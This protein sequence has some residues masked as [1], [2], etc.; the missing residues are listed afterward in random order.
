[1]DSKVASKLGAVV[2]TVLAS[3]LATVMVVVHTEFA[4]FTVKTGK[5]SAVSSVVANTHEKK[6]H[7]KQHV[8]RAAHKAKAQQKNQLQQTLLTQPTSSNLSSN[9]YADLTRAFVAANIPWNAIENPV[10]RQFL[11]KYC[12]QNIPS[13]STL[14]KNY[15][16]RIYNETLASIREDISDSYTWVSVDE[17]SDPMN[18]YIANM[19]V[20]KL[21]PDGPSIPHLVCVKELSKVNSQAIAYFVNKGLQSLY[22]GNIDDSK[23]LLFCTDAA[24]YMVAAAP[25]LKTFYPNLTHVTCLAHGLHRVS[26]TIRNGFPLANSFFSNTKKC[27]CK[28]PSRISIF[29]ENF[30]DIPLPPQPVVTRWGT[31][32]QSVVYYSKYF[33]EVVTVIDKLPETDSAACVKAVKDCLNDSR[34]KKDIAYITSNF[35]FIPAS[36]E[37]LEREKQSLCSQIAIVKG[38]QVNI[39]SAL[40][41]TGKKTAPMDETPPCEP[42]VPEATKTPQRSASPIPNNM[43][44]SVQLKKEEED[45]KSRK[46]RRSSSVEAGPGMGQ[47]SSPTLPPPKV[48]NI[49]AQQPTARTVTFPMGVTPVKITLTTTPGRPTVTTTTSA[50]TTQKVIIVS[51]STASGS[52]S[53]LQRSLSVP[54]VKTVSATCSSNTLSQQSRG[55]SLIINNQSSVTMGAPTHPGPSG[56]GNIVTISTNPGSGGNLTATTVSI[57]G[58]PTTAYITSQSGVPKIRPKSVQLPAKPRPRSGSIVIPMTPNQLAG[59]PAGSSQ[60][61]A[62]LPNVQGVQLKTALHSSKPSLHIKQDSTGMK[63]MP[64][65]NVGSTTKILPKPSFNSG[66]Q[67]P[68]YVMSATTASVSMVTRT[69]P[70]S[71][72]PRVMT[73]NS[74]SSGS[75]PSTSH[76][77][78][79]GST[80]FITKNPTKPI[81]A[82][83]I[84]AQN[85]GIARPTGGKPN[86]IVVQKGSA[87]GFSRGVTLSHGGKEVM[88]KVIMSKSLTSSN[89]PSSPLTTVTVQKPATV[90]QPS[91]SGSSNNSQQTLNLPVSSTQGNVIV[92]DLSQEQLSKNSVLAEILQASGILSDSGNS[93]SENASITAGE[94]SRKA[95][96]SEWIQM[97]SEEQRVSTELEMA[98]SPEEDSSPQTQ[99][100]AIETLDMT[101]GRVVTLEEAVELLGQSDTAETRALLS[102]AGIQVTDSVPSSH[103]VT[104]PGTSGGQN[105]NLH[106]VVHQDVGDSGGHEMMEVIGELDPQTGIYSIHHPAASGETSD[107]IREASSSTVRIVSTSS[108]SGTMDIFSTALASADINLDSFQYMEDGMGM[109]FST[110]V[111]SRKMTERIEQRYCIKFCQKLGENMNR[112][113]AKFVPKLLS[114]EQKDLRR[115]VAQDLLDTANTDPGFLNTVITGD[116]SWVY[117][118]DPETK[119]Q[120]S[121]WK[122]PES[123]RPKKA[124][125]VRSKIKVML[126]VFF[127]VRGIVHHEY[128][129]E[130]QTV[131]KEYYH[132]V[133]WR[134]RDA[135]RRKRPDMWTANNWHLHHD[136]APAHS[137][138]LIHTFLAKH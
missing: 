71:S 126:T 1:M 23:V 64:M 130:G 79:T 32:I 43:M 125:Q 27:F 15:L 90:V 138:Q 136:N 62:N 128:A 2:A 9:F 124:R 25:L 82:V 42:S 61:L 112:V 76:I 121:Q 88:G 60:T 114:P 84:S 49:P 6:C 68:V 35:S 101:G 120:S 44:S 74:T 36:I 70:A 97:E 52:P 39:H 50:S 11:Q 116:E 110:F 73:V 8:Q 94:A 135:V 19:V 103:Q 134:L 21:S 93:S 81:Q 63:I 95:S 132:D 96:S 51:S 75:T 45:E 98:E 56:V 102:Q 109:F 107:T 100:P 46:R 115:D 118:Y 67:A 86:V 26:E 55:A 40:G 10:L 105:N 41:E 91:G 123:P 54:I 78:P 16:D 4:L 131:T 17:T 80:T 83:H 119:R 85:P 122:H 58:I 14:R 59:G 89:L 72:A 3:M 28:A 29:R 57:G 7:L 20:R 37:Q 13:E 106:Q 108:T 92:L 12:K 66:T 22:S 87:T 117:G 5:S 31:W 77:R 24:S 137:S 65:S 113:A 99:I 38:A 47:P 18:R 33:K 30:P 48:P 129:P 111:F 53:I 34:V 133:L 69:V 104:S 127:D